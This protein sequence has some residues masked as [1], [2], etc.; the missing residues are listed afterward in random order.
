MDRDPL[1][2]VPASRHPFQF[3][4][5]GAS[6]LSGTFAT[7]SFGQPTTMVTLLPNGYVTVWGATLFVVGVLGMVAAFW[8]DRLT[9]LLMERIA[10]A[11]LSGLMFVYATILIAR[12]WGPGSASATFLASVGLAAAWRI[13]HV[14][15]ELRILERW[16]RHEDRVKA[17][18]AQY[19]KDLEAG[20]TADTTEDVGD[21][22]G[23]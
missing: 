5:F 9:G 21:E 4:F 16:K 11:G 19:L 17:V 20:Y 22:T 8:R 14:S 23:D 2:G 18:R 3:W 12:A 13:H 6:A 7:L 15:R 10:L 1:T